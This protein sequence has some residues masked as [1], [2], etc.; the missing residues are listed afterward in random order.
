MYRRLKTDL[1]REKYRARENVI[2][3]CNGTHVS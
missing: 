2:Q 1:E 3:T